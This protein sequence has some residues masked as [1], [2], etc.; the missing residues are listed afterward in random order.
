MAI[1]ATHKKM[2]KKRRERER[3]RDCGSSDGPDLRSK[4]HGGDFAF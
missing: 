4:N 2:V 1:G 3:E